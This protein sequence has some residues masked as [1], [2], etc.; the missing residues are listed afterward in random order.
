MKKINCL[1]KDSDDV[2]SYIYK[3]NPQS[4]L[5]TYEKK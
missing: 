1:L 5:L 4:N 3:H 2:A